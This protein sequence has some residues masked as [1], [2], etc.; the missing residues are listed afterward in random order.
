MQPL[1][2][3]ALLGTVSTISCLG[4]L[5][6]GYDNGL[7]GGLVNQAAF[8]TTFDTP[9]ATIIGL[10]VAIYE[11]KEVPLPPLPSEP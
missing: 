6:I 10:I 8:N 4:F 11:G 9:S 3:R 5:L 2:G 7:M 1:S